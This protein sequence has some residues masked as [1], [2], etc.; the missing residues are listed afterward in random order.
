MKKNLPMQKKFVYAVFLLLFFGGTYYAKAQR[1]VGTVTSSWPKLRYPNRLVIGDDYVN[2]VFQFRSK[3]L[4]PVTNYFPSGKNV[5]QGWAGAGALGG[6][7][8][9]TVIGELNGIATIGGHNAD[10]TAWTPLSINPTGEYVGIGTASPGSMLQIGNK[11]VVDYS[12][13]FNLRVY[14]KPVIEPGAWTGAG[15]FGGSAASA[16]IGELSGVAT[17]GGHSAPLDSWAPLSI[18]PTGAY[19]GIGT[20]NP[21]YTLDVN[22]TVNAKDLY[23]NGQAINSIVP[24]LGAITTSAT[25]VGIG[26]ITPSKLLEIGVDDANGVGTLFD[27]HGSAT[28][29]NDLVTDSLHPTQVSINTDAKV[30]GTALTVGGPTYIGSWKDAEA[31]I[32]AEYM[33]SYYL[34]VKK[35]I[36][37]EDFAIANVDTW[38]DEVFKEGYRLPSLTE[39]EDYIQQNKHLPG[40]PSE[41]EVKEKGY[42][43]NQLTIAFLEKIEHLVLY[44]IG[45]QKEIEELKKQVQQ[46]D[47]LKREIE[48]IKAT[49]KK[50]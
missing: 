1:D 34:W 26:N 16:V 4:E 25:S 17:I 7:R 28:F 18:N 21:I 48:A 35:G 37:S 24:A 42:T 39:L 50:Q 32:K 40:I 49:I 22:G 20:L 13:P 46:Y 41:Q 15:A 38:K 33:N 43:V 5:A 44:S 3:S 11:T 9:S 45:Q 36:V 10:L 29:N 30:A 23:I 12:A 31:G 19:V 27:V 8:S 47:G 6:F 2:N 14:G